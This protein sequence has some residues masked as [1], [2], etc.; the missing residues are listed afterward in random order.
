MNYLPSSNSQPAIFAQLLAELDSRLRLFPSD[1]QAE[2]SSWS[3]LLHLGVQAD[4]LAGVATIEEDDGL[5]QC[6]RALA[7]LV[8][9]GLE[10]PQ[11]IPEGWRSGFQLLTVFL[12]D[13][14]VG[15]DAGDSVSQWIEDSRWQ[16][17]ISWFARL[18]TPFLVMNELEEILLNWQNCWC[19]EALTPDEDKEL[20]QHWARLREFGDALFHP[21]EPESDSSLLR[22][23]GFGPES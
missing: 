4:L 5:L 10:D 1:A 2:A 21:T 11:C 12:D 18:E 8:A 22:W 14:A 9:H 23:K 16:R 6:S 15:L 13:L 19:D 3:V 7:S 17:L 20:Q